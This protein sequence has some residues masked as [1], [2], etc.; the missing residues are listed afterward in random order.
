MRQKDIERYTAITRSR[1][2]FNVLNSPVALS[3]DQCHSIEESRE[4]IYGTNNGKS[5]YFAGR[6]EVHE[7]QRRDNSAHGEARRHPSGEA[8][9]NSLAAI[10][11]VSP[12]A[13]NR[14]QREG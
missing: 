3:D 9:G 1:A 2:G 6:V 7:V 8:T 12:S 4:E 5:N 13:G 11:S 10:P 14:N